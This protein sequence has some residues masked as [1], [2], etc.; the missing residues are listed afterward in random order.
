MT[1]AVTALSHEARERRGGVSAPGR[2][3]ANPDCVACG[4]SG[5]VYEHQD[6]A[7]VKVQC[8]VCT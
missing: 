8:P 3:A 1:S 6:G 4:G 5:W 2:V 7:R